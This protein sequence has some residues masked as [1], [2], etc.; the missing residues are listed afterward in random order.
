MLNRSLL[1]TSIGIALLLWVMTLDTWRAG[2]V[3]LGVGATAAAIVIAAGLLLALA[4][5]LRPGA[6][7]PPMT[8]ASRVGVFVAVGA[9]FLAVAGLG[10][11]SRRNRTPTPVQFVRLR[12]EMPFGHGEVS[13]GADGAVLYTTVHG[14]EVSVERSA[15]DLDVLPN[16]QQLAAAH[17]LVTRVMRAA[18]AFADYDAVQRAGG[19][20]INATFLGDDEGA[21]MEHLVNPAYMEDSAVV[22]PARPEA[23][24]FRR[25]GAGRR[26]L[27]GFMF[28]MRR[29]Q[30][31]PQVGGP[32]TKW[33]FHPE[34]FFCMDSI[35]TPRARR[36]ASGACPAGMNSG[37]S[38][39]MLHVWLVPNSYGIF[40]HMMGG[41]HLAHEQG[42]AAHDMSAMPGMAPPAEGGGATRDTGIAPA[43]LGGHQH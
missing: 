30:H 6:H 20:S 11:L 10:V 19:F 23:L 7:H 3:P 2:V 39:E 33:H 5:V 40:S 37:P 41:D 1:L 26:Q 12:E 8:L 13:R 28:M 24:V 29:G 17:D 9:A 31:G 27:I 18:P 22:D 43:P 36:E 21:A 16:E 42:G 14:L 34:T 32:L 15:F 38:A 4:A 35:G 25:D